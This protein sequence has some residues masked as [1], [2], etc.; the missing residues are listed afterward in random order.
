MSDKLVELGQIPKADIGKAVDPE[1][2]VQALER[3]GK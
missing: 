1:L 3:I 2:R